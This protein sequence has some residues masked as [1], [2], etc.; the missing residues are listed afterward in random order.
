[1]LIKSSI[2]SMTIFLMRM[3]LSITH[4]ATADAEYILNLS[5]IYVMVRE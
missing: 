3:L 4:N 1:M 2:N 5:G